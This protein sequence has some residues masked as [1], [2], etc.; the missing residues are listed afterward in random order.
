MNKKLSRN[1]LSLILLVGMLLFFYFENGSLD[2]LIATETN[3][4]TVESAVVTSTDVSPQAGSYFTAYF[5]NP[6]LDKNIPGIETNLIKL[7]DNSKVSVHA[8]IYELDLSNVADA[9]IS[10]KN[11]GVDV[12]IVYDNGQLGDYQERHDIIKS[13]NNAGIQTIPDKRSAFMHNKFFVIDGSTV[14][15]GSFNITVSAAHNN[16]E[17]AV[18]FNI[19]ELALNYEKEFAEMFNDNS[20]GPKSSPDTPYPQISIGELEMFSYF[21]PED[22]V[23]LK[24]IAKIKKA[25]YTIDFL[26]FSFT[27]NNLAYSMSELAMEEDL[28]IRG[29]FD[30]SQDMGVSVCP[31]LIARDKNI[32]GS[33]NIDIKIDGISGKLHEKVIVLDQET[34]IFGSFNFSGNADKSNDE[35]L[36]IVH[37]PAFAKLFMAEF[38]KVF[39][40]GVTPNDSCKKN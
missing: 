24:V 13:L 11:R 9:L 39:D 3:V 14:W 16:Y 37:D 18:V 36:L 28:H 8:A 32:A 19:P 21:A 12:A 23:M 5:T 40:Q 4:P 34:V 31:Y 30:A 29:V 2:N 25:R 27:D 7:I 22:D 10:A 35:N 1:L 20:F 26:S 38:Q 33:G 15:T 17:N 6:P